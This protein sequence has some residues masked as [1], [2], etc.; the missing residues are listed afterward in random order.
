MR[1]SKL[2][3]EGGHDNSAT[4]YFLED[5]SIV[6]GDAGLYPGLRRKRNVVSR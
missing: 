3:V 6:D 1:R 5:G 4:Q 2:P